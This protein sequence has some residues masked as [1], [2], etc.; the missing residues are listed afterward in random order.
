MNTGRYANTLPPC[1]FICQVLHKKESFSGWEWDITLLHIAA[2]L[3]KSEKEA[4]TIFSLLDNSE[5]SE[6]DREHAE[7]IKYELIK[8]MKGDHE[9]DKFLT[10][11]ISNPE[12]RKNAIRKAIEDKNFE[13][14]V[15]LANDGIKCDTEDKPGLALEWYDWLLRIALIQ[16]DTANIIGYARFLFVDGFRHDQDYYGIMKK[17]K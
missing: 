16:E 5:L 8:K 14:A 17:I 12:L 3:V 2:Q 15:S 7:E 4:D 11:Y 6:F 13:K 1:F 10:E 9:A